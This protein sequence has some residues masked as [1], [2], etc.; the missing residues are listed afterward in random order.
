[1][2]TP[3]KK[4]H[5][6]PSLLIPTAATRPVRPPALTGGIWSAPP[7]TAAGLCELTRHGPDPMGLGP[8]DQ[9]DI[10]SLEQGS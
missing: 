2:Q 9:N 4:C 5:A 10:R 6:I 8:S 3:Q 1:M 7:T